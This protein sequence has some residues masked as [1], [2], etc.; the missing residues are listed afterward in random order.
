MVFKTCTPHPRTRTFSVTWCVTNTRNRFTRNGDSSLDCTVTKCWL[1]TGYPCPCQTPAGS[2]GQCANHWRSLS[3]LL[4]SLFKAKGTEVSP[5][6]LL[7]CII[8]TSYSTFTFNAAIH[9][10]IILDRTSSE[11]PPLWFRGVFEPKYLLQTFKICHSLGS[12]KQV[13]R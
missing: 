8:V 12:Q 1:T 9:S 4:S 5:H 7:Q 10:P 2:A 6:C 11:L 3:N 13:N